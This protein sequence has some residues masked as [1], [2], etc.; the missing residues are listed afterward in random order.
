MNFSDQS[1]GA[2]TSWHW[3]FPGGIPAM[4][5]LQDPMVNYSNPGSFNVKL[6]VSDGIHTDT[7]LRHP[8]IT[9]HSIPGTAV[10]PTGPAQICQGTIA[11]LF[12]T[13]DLPGVTAYAWSLT[14]GAA[15]SLAGTGPFAIINWI[16]GFYGTAYVSVAGI[17]ACGIGMSSQTSTTLVT[18]LPNVSLPGINPACSNW[19]PFALSG[20][21]PSGGT[22][23][24]TGI[25]NNLFYAGMAGEG[26]HQVTYIV[27]DSNGCFNSA[28]QNIYVSLCF[29]IGDEES[30]EIRIYPN[31]ACDELFVKQDAGLKEIDDLTITD[32]TGKILLKETNTKLSDNLTIINTSSLT[33]G[34]YFLKISNKKNHYI[35]KIII[36]R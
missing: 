8:Y 6:V 23:T 18:A 21:T 29:G 30:P 17:N 4:S 28:S 25:N 32:V 33:N 31:P 35:K 19:P 20:G 14:P 10:M 11:S 12:Q 16:P 7:L 1:H 9:V 36:Q 2:V 22:Y 15:G 24:G 27:A 26:D 34:L 3:E 5:S 13:S